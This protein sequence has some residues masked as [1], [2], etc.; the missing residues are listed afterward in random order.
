MKQ[1]RDLAQMQVICEAQYAQKQ[2]TFAKL[3]A[4]ENRLRAELHRLDK[5][6][7][8]AQTETLEHIP[9]QAIGADVIW[10]GWLGRSK[11]SVNIA[12]ARIL[13]MKEHHMAEVRLAYGKLLV[14]QQL[15]KDATARHH[16]KAAVASLSKTI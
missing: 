2:A 13:A 15:S 7:R 14:T 16:K 9:M 8:D 6:G 1:R 3:V 12:L 5:M 4:E 11:T 10:Q